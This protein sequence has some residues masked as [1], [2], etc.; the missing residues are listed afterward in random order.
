MLALSIKAQIFKINGIAIDG[1]KI[2]K[3]FSVISDTGTSFIGLPPP[4][5]QLVAAAVKAQVLSIFAPL[6]FLSVAR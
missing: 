6:K 3:K 5:M 1:L 4:V 2:L